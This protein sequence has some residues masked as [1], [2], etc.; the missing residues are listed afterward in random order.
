LSIQAK[1][2]IAIFFAETFAVKA[3]NL[4]QLE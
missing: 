3:S 1:L 2:I 4:C